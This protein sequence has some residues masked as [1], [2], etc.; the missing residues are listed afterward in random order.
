MC[1]SKDQIIEVVERLGDAQRQRVLDFARRLTK[2]EG[3]L[4]RDLVRF[5]GA[6]DPA[7]LEVMSG[8]IEEGCEQVH[9]NG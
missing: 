5:A 6:I 9:S 3:T 2:P 1:T 7:D 4:G 8:A